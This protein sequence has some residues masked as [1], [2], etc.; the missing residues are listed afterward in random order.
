MPDIKTK[1]LK[2]CIDLEKSWSE[3][4]KQIRYWYDILLLTNNL[5]QEGMES[6]IANDP[7]VAYN[8]SVYLI[9][10]AIIAHKMPTEGLEM[11]EIVDTSSIEQFFARQWGELDEGQRRIGRQSW[12]RYQTALTVAT[13]WYSVLALA[14]PDKLIAETWNPIEVF[15]HFSR[16]PEIGMDKCA[17]IY[18][19]TS[20]EANRKAKLN[21]WVL[22]RSFVGDVKVYN[23]YFIDEDGDPSNTVLM[24]NV[25]VIPPFKLNPTIQASNR[26]PIFVSPVGGLPDDG[27][28]VTKQTSWQKHFG[29]SIIATDAEEFNNQ[30]K[31]LTYVQQTVRDTA[32]PR[33]FERSTG[34]N[35]LTPE[36]LFRRGTIY[37]GG[38]NDSIDPLPVPP[39]PLELRT[40]LFDYSN[41]IQRGLF[42]WTLLGNIQGQMSG[43]MMSQVASSSMSSL[44]PYADGIRDLLTDI[45]NYWLYEMRERNIS[46]RG[47]TIPKETPK[48]IKFKVSLNV[49]IPGSLV[50]RATIA[51]ILNPQLRFD[52]ATTCDLMFPEINNPIEIQ[53]RVN[54][55]EAVM[56]EVAQA[57]ALIESYREVAKMSRESG[58][59]TTADLY[60]KAANSLEAQM[61]TP[62]VPTTAQPTRPKEMRSAIP[63]EETMPEEFEGGV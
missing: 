43:Y 27:A 28:I 5:Y 54:K 13:G 61:S 21:N 17:H 49:N 32:T 44:A 40:I 47:F 57:V 58:D 23:Y 35:I 60:E 20:S 31:M 11:Q 26:L 25:I 39:M 52:F 2:E 7:R 8:L 63:R 16:D 41:R 34:G 30:N 46:I 1:I 4:N 19:L 45:N 53:A 12:L 24:N 37:R 33:W 36:T 3:R 15:P 14:T 59:T 10:S 29:E 42:P 9:K 22:P 50:Q 48:D 6:V 55:D 51:K 18:S 56:G 38:P 62:Q